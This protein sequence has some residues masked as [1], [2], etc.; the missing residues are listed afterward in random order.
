MMSLLDYGQKQ[1]NSLKSNG[2]FKGHLGEGVLDWLSFI[3]D[4]VA[5]R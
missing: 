1:C 5:Q 3:A 4:V 2:F